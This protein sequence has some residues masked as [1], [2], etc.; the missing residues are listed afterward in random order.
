MKKPPE[1]VTRASQKIILILWKNFL[2]LSRNWLHT[3]FVLISPAVFLLVIAIA[4]IAMEPHV[5]PKPIF[6]K[7]LDPLSLYLSKNQTLP[8]AAD[9]SPITYAIAYSPRCSQLELL[10]TEARNLLDPDIMIEGFDSSREMKI[11]LL[12]RNIFAGVEFPDNYVNSTIEDINELKFTLKFPSK[13]RHEPM[14]PIYLFNWFTNMRFPKFR[15]VG[16]R[17]PG[18]SDGG[19]QPGYFI[20]GFIPVQ[21]ALSRAFIALKQ[22]ASNLTDLSVPDFYIQRF[23]YPPFVSDSLYDLTELILTI[24]MTL[25]LIYVSSNLVKHMVVEKERQMKEVMKIMG[26]DNWLHWVAWYLTSFFLYLV[27][28]GIIVFM[29]KVSN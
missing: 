13:L 3:I 17:W 28:I 20:E 12:R 23:P 16:S 19:S 5:F 18:N 15:G 14:E 11:N 24:S 7:P 8:L 25:S 6:Y 27:P 1:M 22:N 21:S 2:I 10:V 4:R 9:V 26:M 29:L